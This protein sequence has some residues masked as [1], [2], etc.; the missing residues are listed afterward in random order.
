MGQIVNPLQSNFNA[1]ELGLSLDGRVDMA[2]YGNGSRKMRNFIPT[3]QGPAKR[4]MGR[5]Y[6]VEVKNSANRTWLASFR[7]SSDQAFV[8]EI[9]DRYMRFH[10]QHGQLQ[11]GAVTAYN[12]ATNYTIGDLASNAGVNYYCIAATVGNAP[13]NATYWYALTGTI[14]EIPTP[15]VL[16][17]LTNTDG[18]FRL[19]MAQTADV[20]FIA[21]SKYPIQQLTRVN[22]TRWT[23]AAASIKNGPFIGTDPDATTTVYASAATGVGITLT[24]SVSTF[25]ADDVGTLFLLEQ[26]KIDAYKVWE[27][28][29]AIVINDERRSDGNVYK[30]LNA[31]NTG[32]VKP[33]HQ[34]GAKFDGDNGIQWQYEHSGYGVALITAQAGATATATVISELPSQAVGVANA[35]TRWSKSAWSAGKGYPAL[36]CFFRERLALVRGAKLWFSVTSDFLNFANREGSDT[37]PDS[38]ISIDITTDQL[39]DAVWMT[40]A[41]SLLVGTVGTEFSIG[42]TSTSDVFGPG[43]I[44]AKKQT[45]HGGR[46]VQPVTV[47]DS[48]LF[49]QRAGRR[50]REIRFSFDSDGYQTVDM[51][52]LNEDITRGRI[53]QMCFQ[54]EPFSVVWA[55]CNNGDLLGFTFSR[56]Q[57][58]IGWH[59][60][61]TVGL[62]ESVVS[63]PTPDGLQDEIWTISKYSINGATK[64]YVEYQEKD[65]IA[66]DTA[67]KDAVFMDCAATYSGV[68]TTVATMNLI[69]AS[70]T[71]DTTG[72]L[73]NSAVP[74]VNGDIGKVVLLGYAA[75][76]IAR[77][78]ILSQVAG[79][80]TVRLMDA[81]PVA[82]QNTLS[83]DWA[84]GVTTISGLGYLEGQSVQVLVD[85]DAHPECTVTAGSITLQRTGTVV[86]AGLA[87]D[88]ELVTMRIEAGAQNGT[89][90][91]KLKRI[92]RVILRLLETLGVSFGTTT[93]DMGNGP[94]DQIQFRTSNTPMNT[95]P[96]VFSG[97]KTL[98]WPGGYDTEGRVRILCNQPLPCTIVMIAPQL[99]V[100]DRT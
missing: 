1:G 73:A 45:G 10:T 15:Y 71:Q 2:K 70:Y 23:L 47:N 37:V 54:E 5:R 96:A 92:H 80:A 31:A 50:L 34:E 21:H 69:A 61:P 63:I 33:T 41:N 58:V 53:I 90:Q 72:T 42:E 56:E 27:V 57:D 98:T 67:L 49:M 13:P 97:D 14:Y 44:T 39:N 89:A 60:H 59:K 8:I 77:V 83:A 99:T 26:K 75:G 7:F 55:V 62:A 93:A 9:G 38:A 88:A 32:S 87:A 84:W 17:D 29:K 52:V 100:E 40:P 19:S 11:T 35:S 94:V 74:F 82:Y 43:N 18:T 12:G 85:G 24:A 48:I 95:P 51:T 4:R 20:I 86:Q 46:Q 81:I 30:A 64:R 79:I 36:I 66:A 78:E 22:N 28:N 16:A 25:T 3:V 91:G 65:W 76:V 6:V 68:N